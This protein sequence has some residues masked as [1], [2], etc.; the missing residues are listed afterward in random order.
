MQIF[1]IFRGEHAP[2]PPRVAFVT[3][4]SSLFISLLQITILHLQKNKKI[5]RKQQQE[6]CEMTVRSSS[7]AAF[8]NLNLIKSTY[9]IISHN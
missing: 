2:G 4:Q 8:L 6:G 9:V 1:K 5:I 7:Q 3:N